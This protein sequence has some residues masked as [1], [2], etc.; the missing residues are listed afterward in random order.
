MRRSV[1]QVDCVLAIDQMVKTLT[2]EGRDFA[3]GGIKPPPE[4]PIDIQINQEAWKAA[5]R[6]KL[7]P[8][9]GHS[10]TTTQ[11]KS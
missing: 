10:N 9:R 4:L 6:H 8:T 1:D 2:A 5:F 3:L 11:D 7:A